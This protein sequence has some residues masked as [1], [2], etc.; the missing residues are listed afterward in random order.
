MYV[1]NTNEGG[2]KSTDDI[3]LINFVNNF[4]NFVPKQN[5]L[6]RFFYRSETIV[7]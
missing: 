7:I 4:P 6:S 2:N 3:F 5:K 1:T